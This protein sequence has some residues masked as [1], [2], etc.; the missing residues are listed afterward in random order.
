MTA[1]AASTIN[2]VRLT[3]VF[4]EPTGSDGLGF[5]S[6]DGVLGGSILLG[7][8]TII[9]TIPLE[10]VAPGYVVAD[11]PFAVVGLVLAAIGITAH[12]DRGD[13]P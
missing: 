6:V 3:A 8:A 1:L 10:G 12:R 4:G 13:H 5:L 2:L 7:V 11:L 9:A